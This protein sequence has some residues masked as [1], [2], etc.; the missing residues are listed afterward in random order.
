MTAREL[1]QL[2][3]FDPTKGKWMGSLAEKAAGVLTARE[4]KAEEFRKLN[5]EIDTANRRLNTALA[6]QR[7]A[8]ATGD[9]KAKEEADQAVLNARV[10]LRD[11]VIHFGF[12]AEKIEV[13]KRQAGA[14]ERHAGAAETAARQRGEARQELTAR[15]RANLRD[16]AIDNIAKDQQVP[17]AVARA[18]AEA[19]RRNVA[20]DEKAFREQLVEREYQSL[21]AAAEGRTVAPVATNERV[22]DFSSIGTK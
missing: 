3:S 2:A 14:A 1:L 7:L 5:R 17:V 10:A 18:R 19:Q 4:A 12:E 15:D 22:V 11:K 9:Q 16:K 8:Y 13:Q 6:Q 20:F 21:L